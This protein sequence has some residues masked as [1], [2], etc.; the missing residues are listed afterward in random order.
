LPHDDYCPADDAGFFFCPRKPLIL[1]KCRHFS[2]HEEQIM[3]TNPMLTIARRAAEEAGKI[4]QMGLR[5]IEKIKIEEKGIFSIKNE[6]T[7]WSS[8]NLIIF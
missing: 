1:L 7:F 8:P 5:Q 6:K 2:D 4:L 3:A